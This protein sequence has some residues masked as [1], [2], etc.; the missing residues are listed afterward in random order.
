MSG[1]DI[2]D[3]IRRHAGAAGGKFMHENVVL[4]AVEEILT[5]QSLDRSAVSYMGA[6]MLSLQSGA[7]AEPAVYAG[8]LK[9]LERALGHVP[10]G[11]LLAKAGRIAQV[12]VAVA[13][14]QIEQPAVRTHVDTSWH[15]LQPAG[16]PEAALDASSCLRPPRELSTQPL[17]TQPF[18]RTQ[19]LKPAL[20]CVQ[21][22]LNAQPEGVQPTVSHTGLE[23]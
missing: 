21:C 23:P 12:I 6:L 3:D 18:D 2:F 13:N 15:R 16:A 9:L 20:G 22:L 7:G 4:A 10:R 5:Q 14:T 8:V 1:E 11:L 19:V 17:T